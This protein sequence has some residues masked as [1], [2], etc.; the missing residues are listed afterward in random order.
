MQPAVVRLRVGLEWGDK[1]CIQNFEEVRMGGRGEGKIRWFCSLHS[2]FLL[3][4]LL[5]P[6]DGGDVLLPNVNLPST[7]YTVLYPRR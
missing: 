2:S 6:E 3:G 4:L 5:N 7:D 1:K